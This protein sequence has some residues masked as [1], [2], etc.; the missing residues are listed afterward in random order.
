MNSRESVLKLVEK[1]YF[2]KVLIK[3]TRPPSI[4]FDLKGTKNR[5]KFSNKISQSNLSGPIL[6]IGSG[7]VKNGNTKGLSEKIFERRKAMD[8]KKYPGVE[9]VGSV[10]NIPL[11]SNSTAGVLFQGVIEHIDNPKKAIEEISRILKPGGYVY[12]EAPF[13]QH[14]HYDPVDHYRFTDD[15]LKKI[16]EQS[17]FEVI[18]YGSL[19]GPSA[20]LADVVIEYMAVFFRL[21]ILYWIVKW[22]L[23]WLL[24]WIKYLDILFINNKNN[25]FLSLGVYAIAKNKY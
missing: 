11:E 8:Y 16:F 17:N 7:P 15:G 18:D 5:K 22:L 14:F 6:D 19:Y 10:E 24:F 1:F 3:L 2:L 20:V 4:K 21:P 12:V 25:K 9:I 13:L 23:G